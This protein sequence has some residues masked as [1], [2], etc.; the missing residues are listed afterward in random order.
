M[1]VQAI[2]NIESGRS[3]WRKFGITVGIVLGLLGGLFF[4]RE[5]DYYSYF[6]ILSTVFLFLGLVLPVLLKPIHKIWMTLAIF[7]GWFMSRLIL[8]VV[9]YLV[10]IPIGLSMRLLGKDLLNQKFDKSA[11]TYWIKRDK[12]AFDRTR[13]EKLF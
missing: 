13:Y 5:R 8:S 6:L 11:D 4:W 7:I 10:L 9:F 1:I 3:E 12:K 2:K